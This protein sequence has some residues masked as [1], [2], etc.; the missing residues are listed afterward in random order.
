MG[1]QLDGEMIADLHGVPSVYR[2]DRIPVVLD[3]IRRCNMPFVVCG[4]ASF[5]T[6]DGQPLGPDERIVEYGSTFIF[7]PEIMMLAANYMY[8][9]QREF[10]L[11]FLKKAMEYQVCVHRHPWDLPNLIM[12]NTGERHFGTD[13]YQNMMLWAIPAAIAGKDIRGLCLADGLV[14]R[15]LKAAK[16]SG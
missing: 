16:G 14:A 4:A 10:G 8:E 2:A 7:L 9:G 15:V 11:E 13:Y 6:P 12:G 3:T 1:Y 5:A